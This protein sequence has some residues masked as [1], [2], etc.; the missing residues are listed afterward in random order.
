MKK[1]D[2][3]NKRH[4]KNPKK[5]RPEDNAPSQKQEE[6]TTHSVRKPKVNK[7]GGRERRV[8]VPGKVERATPRRGQN[9]QPN[10]LDRPNK[11]KFE[12]RSSRATKW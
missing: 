1:A 2:Q 4:K 7:P 11:R 6:T 3:T 5:V 9:S 10:Q 8:A 12:H